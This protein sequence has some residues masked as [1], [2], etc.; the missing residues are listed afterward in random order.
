MDFT[1]ARYNMVEQQIR[2]W[3]VLDFDLLDVLGE[4]PREHFVLPEQQGIAYTDQALK[5]SNGG[6]MLEPKVVARL[7]QALGL[8]AGD[9]VLEVGSGSGYATAILAKMAGQVV[10]VDIDAAQQ[11]YAAAA[12]AALGLDNIRF[13]A[14]DGLAAEADG[15][16]FSAIYVG[17]SVPQPPKALSHQLADGGRMVVIVGTAPV[18]RAKLITRSGDAFHETTLFDTVAPLLHSPATPVPSVFS[19]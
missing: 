10:S 7:I 6:R 11:Q 18:M 4:V 13:Q 5:L 16:P 9:T 14:A 17:G 12:V 19:F 1:L 2:P 15:A 3:D 8:N